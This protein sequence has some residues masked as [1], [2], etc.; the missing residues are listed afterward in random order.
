MVCDLKV[1][2][3]LCTLSNISSRS[4]EGMNRANGLS[5][6]RNSSSSLE[7]LRLGAETEEQKMMRK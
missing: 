5:F 7:G 4:V 6:S 1:W 2:Y 3:L